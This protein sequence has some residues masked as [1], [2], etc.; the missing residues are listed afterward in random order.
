MTLISGGS[1]T[2]YTCKVPAELT[3]SRANYR[4]PY[5]LGF[6]RILG[7]G[8]RGTHERSF[9]LNIRGDMSCVEFSE[10]KA[11]QDHMGIYGV[12][13]IQTFLIFG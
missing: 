2:H 11:P 7:G 13:K 1:V 9:R 3:L 4:K 6:G 10:R 8:V 5:T 12:P